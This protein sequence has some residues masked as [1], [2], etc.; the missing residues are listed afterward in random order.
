MTG[1]RGGLCNPA[2]AASVRNVV[3]NYGYGGG[4][5]FR[6]GFRGGCGRGR[7]WSP[8]YGRG[9]GWYPP[10]ADPAYSAPAADELDILKAEADYLK[11]SLDAISTRIDELEKKPAE[12][13]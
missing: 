3:G 6:R 9:Y 12:E 10:V 8:G 1:G 5:G 4:L 7:G 11:K 13:S 2:T